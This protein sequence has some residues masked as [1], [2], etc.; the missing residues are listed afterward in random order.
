M[1]TPLRVL[2]QEVF[3]SVLLLAITGASMGAYLGLAMLVV[4]AAR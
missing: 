1:N 4:R 3:Q 2:L